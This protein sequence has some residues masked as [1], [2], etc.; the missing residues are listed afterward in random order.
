M[1]KKIKWIIAKEGLIIIAI[2]ALLY[3]FKTYAPTLPF[4]YPKIKLEFK[5]GSSNIIEIYPDMTTPE[6]AGRI[7]PSDLVRKYH[8]PS[9]ELITKR[10]DK[11]IQ[12]NKKVSQLRDIK[13][14]N[15]MQLSLYRVY[16]NFLFQ[17]LPFRTL[18]IYLF[19]LLIRF[20]VWAVRILKGKELKVIPMAG[21]AIILF[22]AGC[23]AAPEQ[24]TSVKDTYDNVR[25][26]GE[27]TISSVDRKGF[28]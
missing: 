7:S 15:G 4:P 28:D 10:I 27:L 16:F 21:A 9:P 2:A 24:A 5:D 11:F 20:I 6:L 1:G 13:Y 3:I 19:L 25:V 26:S 14:V 17:P 22:I 18:S 8:S 12:D 23:A